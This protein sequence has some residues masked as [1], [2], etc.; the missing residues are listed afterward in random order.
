MTT[1]HGRFTKMPAARRNASGIINSPC[2]SPELFLLGLGLDCDKSVVSLRRATAQPVRTSC[3]LSTPDLTAGSL[4]EITPALIERLEADSHSRTSGKHRTAVAYS[5]PPQRLACAPLRAQPGQT[6]GSAGCQKPS[7]GVEAPE[8]PVAALP[9]RRGTLHLTARVAPFQ[10]RIEPGPGD[11]AHLRCTAGYR[12]PGGPS[13]RSS[14][15]T[16]T[17]TS[18]ARRV[19]FATIR[20]ALLRSARQQGASHVPRPKPSRVH[21]HRWRGRYRRRHSGPRRSR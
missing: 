6:H 17:I 12:R 16:R 9:R 13:H 5:L 8:R 18:I 4:A 20:N 10:S 14:V 3:S 11:G 1:H 2:Q 21:G 19:D 15:A 7:F